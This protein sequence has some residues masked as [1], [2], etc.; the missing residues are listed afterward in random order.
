VRPAQ[1]ALFE[2]RGG[3]VGQ[4]RGLR[5]VSAPHL[6]HDVGHGGCWLDEAH[7]AQRIEEGHDARRADV[8][9]GPRPNGGRRHEPRGLRSPERAEKKQEDGEQRADADAAE[10]RVPGGLQRAIQGGVP[11]DDGVAREERLGLAHRGVMGLLGVPGVERDLAP[12]R[13]R[14]DVTPDASQHRAPSAQGVE[15][16]RTLAQDHAVHLGDQA[17]GARLLG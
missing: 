12:A 4:G 14:V 2:A 1:P 17:V 6:L 10:G 7:G 16:L 11:V 15:V 8:A 3:F 13:G 9:L 5:P